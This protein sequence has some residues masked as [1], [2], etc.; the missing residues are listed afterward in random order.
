MR[1]L[2]LSIT[3]PNEWRQLN[4]ISDSEMN[5]LRRIHRG[6]AAV[7]SD[8]WQAVRMLP[9]GDFGLIVGNPA[10]ASVIVAEIIEADR[11]DADVGDLFNG[12]AGGTVRSDQIEKVQFLGADA[13]R[14]LTERT[15]ADGVQSM[16]LEVLTRIDGVGAVALEVSGVKS[17]FDRDR[18]QAILDTV[19]RTGH[20]PLGKAP[21]YAPDPE[22]ANRL[23]AFGYDQLASGNIW[24]LIGAGVLQTSSLLQTAA[25][26]PMVP[27]DL[28]AFR[29]GLT[30]PSVHDATGWTDVTAVRIDGNELPRWTSLDGPYRDRGYTDGRIGKCQGLLADPTTD[31]HAGALLPIADVVYGLEGPDMTSVVADAKH[32]GCQ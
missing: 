6:L 4:E 24:T 29:G 1:N 13:W 9:G 26:D 32:L 16:H 15:D 28:G 21:D 10:D 7:L 5:Q 27:V 31:G 12:L 22:I 2:G 30:G 11:Q 23:H 14:A 3:L 25:N 8:G 20:T 17:F 18:A 19:T